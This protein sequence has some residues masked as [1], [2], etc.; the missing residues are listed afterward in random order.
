[1]R[2]K[3]TIAA[4]LIALSTLPN[5][6]FASKYYSRQLCS[7]P[8]YTCIKVKRHD[9]WDKLFP[10][11][12]EQYIIRKINRMNIEL[13]PGLILAIPNNLREND[14]LAF[15]PFPDR[16]TPLDRTVIM[17]DL[18]KQAFGAYDASGKLVR[19]GPVS[20]GQDYCPDIGRPCHSP[21]GIFYVQYKEGPDCFSSKF[22]IPDGGA[23]MPYC[24]YF[25]GGYAMHG[26][27]LP[28]YNA[29]HGCI[30]MFTEDAEWL[31]KNFVE[32]GAKTTEV[33]VQQ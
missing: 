16:I 19:W 31:N 27:V 20:G 5:V 12:E 22:P 29:S 26:C 6:A 4:L 23:P 15:A 9:S 1:M 13:E 14:P 32:F 24:M 18:E 21:T 30:R 10:D 17:V 8:E 11:K 25:H 7:N 2:I 3:S 33:I 28:G